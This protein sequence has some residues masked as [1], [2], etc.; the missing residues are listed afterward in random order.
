MLPASIPDVF[1][2]TDVAFDIISKREPFFESS[3]NV[4]K[5]AAQHRVQLLISE[6][7]IAN[8]IYLTF[9]IYKLKDGK[10][11]LIDF[12][13]ATGIVQSGK[14]CILRALES[15]FKDKEDGL[16]YFTALQAS[17]DFFLTRNIRDYRKFAATELPVYTP[18]KFC[19]AF[20][21]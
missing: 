13:Q 19:E 3:V 5:L 21:S 6:I 12:V 1:L 8:L 14:S 4:L 18:E 11:R 2:D 20:V 9:D 16:Q 10:S 15:S 7:S 17:A